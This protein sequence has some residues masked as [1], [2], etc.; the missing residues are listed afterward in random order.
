M[1]GVRA[2]V[3]QSPNQTKKKQGQK[4]EKSDPPIDGQNHGGGGRKGLSLLEDD[5]LDVE[6]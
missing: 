2:M 4:S 1:W 5:D 3:S 6:E